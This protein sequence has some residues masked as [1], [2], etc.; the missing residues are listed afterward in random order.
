MRNVLGLLDGSLCTAARP[1]QE[2]T[3]FFLRRAGGCAQATRRCMC[4]CNCCGN[5]T[6]SRARS[7]I[8]D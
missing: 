5:I 3:D 6:G 2:K 8:A 4:L 1:P 7:Q